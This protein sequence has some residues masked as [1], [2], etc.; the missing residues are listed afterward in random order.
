MMVR[1]IVLVMALSITSWRVHLAEPAEI[2]ADP[3][4]DHHRF[5]DRVAQ[6]RQHRRQHRQREFP[7]EVG[8]EAQDD[9]DVV[10]VGDDAGHRELPFEAERQVDHDADDH[11][12]SASRP[13]VA[14]SSPT[15][16][17][18]NSTRCSFT[19]GVGG[20]QGRHHLLALL[21]RG[22]G[23]AVRAL[24]QRQADHH[25]ARRAEVLHLA[26]RDSRACSTWPRTCSRSGGL[27]VAHLHHR[28]AGEFDR[29]VQA[30]LPEEE[31]GRGKGQRRKSR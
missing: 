23:L 17:P 31:H 9:D 22:G 10:Q 4:E 12:S 15:C 19:S 13:S 14:S 3:V 30:L 27:R 1:E 28:A 29:Q 24:L 6:H 5:V 8:E 11:H 18:T 16:G 2:L 20:L 7:L 26:R 25:V 21:R